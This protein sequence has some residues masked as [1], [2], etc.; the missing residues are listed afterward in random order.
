MK[1]VIILKKL[2]NYQAESS[3]ATTKR[4]AGRV[5]PVRMELEPIFASNLKQSKVGM[6]AAQPS[7]MVSAHNSKVKGNG[8]RQ[9]LMAARFLPLS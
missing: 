4:D 3:S 5:K 9:F 2:L 8:Y 6:G 1:S 7:A